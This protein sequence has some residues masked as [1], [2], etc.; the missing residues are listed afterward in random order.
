MEIKNYYLKEKITEINISSIKTDIF[1]N[2]ADFKEEDVIA[3]ASAIKKFGILYPLCIRKNIKDPKGYFV[4]N[5]AE[6]FLALKYLKV[7]K[8]PSI[9]FS[10]TLPESIIFY[11]LNNENINIFKKAEFFKFLLKKGNY[12]PAEL[13][14]IFK[15][16]LGELNTILL[17]LSLNK[18]EK[19]IFIS[20]NLDINFLKL[21]LLLN[22]RQ[23]SEVLNKLVAE[24]LRYDD[25]IK[26]TENVLHPK[27]EPLKVGYIKSDKL[28]LNSMNKLSNDLK[29]LG[30]RTKVKAEQE[31]DE[32]KYSLILQNG[33][34]QL[35]FDFSNIS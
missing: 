26:Y 14:E 30:I 32:K 20:R 15:I 2:T 18:E 23:K 5:N 22:A 7:K 19:N 27:E 8:A 3:K 13:C 31:G 4:F 6:T 34:G 10:Y 24:N 17:P 21:F 1:I 16:S 28:I 12:R 35:S 9:I 29:A 11:L 25:L 33:N